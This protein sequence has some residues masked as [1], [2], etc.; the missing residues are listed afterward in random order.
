MPDITADEQLLLTDVKDYLHITWQDDKTDKNIIDAINSSK[1]R[2][3][4]IAGVSAIDFTEDYL[5]RD[6]LKDR[7]RYINSN[8][9]EM[10]EKNFQAELV[11]LHFKYQVAAMS[12]EVTS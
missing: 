12:T 8:A 3:R 4:D 11:S 6:L 9:L 10:F 1:A 2:L 5:A 7:C